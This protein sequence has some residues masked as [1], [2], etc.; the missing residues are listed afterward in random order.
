MIN[1]VSGG[2]GFIGSHLIENL[3][4]LNEKV[5]CLDN[6]SSGSKSNIEKWKNNPL[7]DF[8]EHDITN[9]IDL[10]IDRV[11][12]LACP[13]SPF[14]YQK[15]PI[16]TSKINFIGTYNLLKLAK[17]YNARFLF[18]SSSE[19]YG[20]SE[21][22]IQ[23]ENYYGYL[24]PVGKRSCYGE[25]K[26]FAESLCFDFLRSNNTDIRVARLFNIY[27]PN[28]IPNDG[29][30]ISNFICQAL[31]G[32]KLTLY[33][34]GSQIR[35]FCYISD[36]IAGLIKFMNSNY[37]GPINLGNPN[38]KFNIKDLANLVIEKINPSLEI[39]LKPLPEDDPKIR[40]PNIDFAKRFL[41]WDPQVNF[42]EGLEYTIDYFKNTLLSKK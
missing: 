33:G 12:H 41:N 26:R 17:K 35:S 39:D 20:D 13:A 8:L 6:L 21:N 27:G 18:T 7:F 40:K 15:N 36:L 14:I 38:E 10:K 28:M 5:I 19:I 31:L 29:R 34:D 24:N 30:V 4:S 22:K 3:I 16:M 32:K 42:N 2:A 1:L 37:M 9:F 11:W 25:G 23:N